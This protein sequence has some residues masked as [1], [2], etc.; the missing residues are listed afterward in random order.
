MAFTTSSNVGSASLI[1]DVEEGCE[2]GGRVCGMAEGMVG[3]VVGDTGA[4]E[5]GVGELGPVGGQGGISGMSVG[6]VGCW[7]VQP[8][9]LGVTVGE[10]GS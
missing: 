9:V 1:W 5:V 4:S 6:E 8:G 3:I 2:C 7:G 10:V